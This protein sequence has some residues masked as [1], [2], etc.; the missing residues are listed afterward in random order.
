MKSK[1]CSNAFRSV[2]KKCAGLLVA[3][4][5]FS[6]I[7]VGML[8]LIAN[9]TIGDVYGYA[10]TFFMK[11]PEEDYQIIDLFDPSE[12]EDT[13]KDTIDISQIEFPQYE[14][15]YGEISIPDVD[16]L[17]PLIYGDTDKA[18]KK[19]ACQYIGSSI[20]GYGGT[21]MIGAHVNRHFKNLHNVEIGDLVQIRTTYGVYTYE[22]KYVGV[23]DASE[24]NLYDLATDDENVVLYTC[25]Y[26]R[27]SLGN[28]K[29][30]FFVCAD[31]VSGPMIVDGGA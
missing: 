11:I 20:I 1:V 19:G 16:I 27:T 18:L 12:L 23:H 22:V 10:S 28:V 13:L 2:I 9:V 5:V 4:F 21:T 14:K 25:Y 17:C 30:R 7:I 24:K 8:W 26:Q 6:V 3:P 31:Y 29:K 15:V